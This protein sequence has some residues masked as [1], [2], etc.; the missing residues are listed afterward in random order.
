MLLASLNTVR[1]C[2]GPDILIS[3]LALVD[4]SSRPL[5]SVVCLLLFAP[6]AYVNV[7]AAGDTVCGYYFSSS[8]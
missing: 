3:H 2:F 5:A 8:L 6:I 4:K 7:V 1:P